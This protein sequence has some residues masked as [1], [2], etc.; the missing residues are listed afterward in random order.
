MRLRRRERRDMAR[1]LADDLEWFDEHSPQP[2][3]SIITRTTW[4]MSKENAA[5]LGEWCAS[6]GFTIEDFLGDIQAEAKA[7]AKLNL[8]KRK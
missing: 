6:K 2:D 4:S 1:Q 3:G 5:A 8:S 7:R